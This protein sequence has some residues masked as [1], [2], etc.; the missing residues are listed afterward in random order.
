MR[1][2]RTIAPAR[3]SRSTDSAAASRST[4]GL[5]SLGRSEPSRRRIQRR[6]VHRRR[7]RSV[8]GGVE[9]VATADT[10]DNG[11][12]PP[13]PPNPR[14]S[15]LNGVSTP[16]GS[17]RWP[18][19]NLPSRWRERAAGLRPTHLTLVDLDRFARVLL[20]G[21]ARSAAPR[22]GWRFGTVGPPRASLATAFTGPLVAPRRRP[23]YRR[24]RGSAARC[25]VPTPTPCPG[26]RVPDRNR[27]PLCRRRGRPRRPTDR[28]YPGRALS[29]R[30]PHVQR[31]RRRPARRD[32]R[33]PRTT[34]PN[35]A[36]K[37]TRRNA[38]RPTP[39]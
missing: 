24:Y 18:W 16:V 27:G 21:S 14:R 26:R 9:I 20:R 32:R 38:G 7:G 39:T 19:R 37:Y 25:S 5:A 2:S 33:T 10:L 11:G 12:S 29:A 22:N 31:G 3:A 23:R 30:H 13:R 4:S 35:A 36:S 34:H 6:R 8:A 15:H 17:H 28:F 1:S